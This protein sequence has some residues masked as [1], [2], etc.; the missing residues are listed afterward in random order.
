M[1]IMQDLKDHGDEVCFISHYTA[2]IEDYSC[3][4]PVVL[5]YSPLYW[6]ID[7]LYVHVIHRKNP[8]IPL[9]HIW[10]ADEKDIPVFYTTRH[11]C[12]RNL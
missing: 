7:Y 5:G 6:L 3:V 9:W 10:Y 11:H 12:G 1:D 4:K 2:I 8:C